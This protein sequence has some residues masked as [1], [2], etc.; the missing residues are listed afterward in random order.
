MVATIASERS[1]IHLT[2]APTSFAACVIAYSSAYVFSFAPKPPP[3]SGAITRQ[4]DSGTPQ[5]TAT[6]VRTKC[7][8]WVELYSVSS[9]AAAP[10][11]AITARAS[12]G[13]GVSRWL[14]MVWRITTGAASKTASKPSVLCAIVQQRLPGASSCTSGAPGS[15]AFSAWITGGSGS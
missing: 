10:Q 12:I 3:T 14:S 2:G 8:T 6:N 4:R 15:S 5:T 9:S 11:L 13:T 7:G 1:S